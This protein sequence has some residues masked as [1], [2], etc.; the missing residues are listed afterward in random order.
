[1]TKEIPDLRPDQIQD[2]AF[3]LSNPKCGNLSDPGTGK[4]PSVCVYANYRWK[5]HGERTCWEMPKSLLLKN[6]EELIRFTEFEADDVLIFDHWWERVNSR[7]QYRV[8]KI[9]DLFKEDPPLNELK[10]RK[11]LSEIDFMNVE[12]AFREIVQYQDQI[13]SEVESK[14]K[15]HK[16]RVKGKMVTIQPLMPEI[17]R[18]NFDPIPPKVPVYLMGFTARKLHW[19][20]LPEDTTL[21]LVDEWHMAYGTSDSAQSQSLF[22][23][24][25]KLFTH[26]VAM[27]GTLMNG[28]LD[29]TY[30]FIHCVQPLYYGNYQHFLRIHAGFIDDYGRVL[31]WTKTE[32]VREIL[33]RHGV[34]HSFAEVY[35]EENKVTMIEKVAM[36]EKHRSF[37]D[38]FHDEAMLEL[39]DGWLEGDLPGVATIRATQIMA[40]PEVF[41]LDIGG[42]SEKDERVKLHLVNA[43]EN[44]T[45]IVLFA[46]LVPEQERLVELCKEHGLRTGLINGNVSDRKRG[47]IDQAFRNGE[48]D[49]VVAS[50][51]TASV[52]FNWGHVDHIIFVS[53]DY[54]DTSFLQA[55]RRAMRGVRE[56]PLRITLLQYDESIDQRK[57][58]IVVEKSV[59]A[60]EVDPTREI[61]VA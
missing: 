19:K 49:A 31:E 57:W 42:A 41:G 23:A 51:Q 53:V 10:L 61:L 43:K 17:L 22:R 36:G 5:Y 44:N 3:Y 24:M 25:R 20:K 6:K 15:V 39:E 28:R 26:M 40:H 56:K 8:G 9:R 38:K 37:Y 54:M 2:L 32:R 30:V 7:Y 50:P 58:A 52:G 14:L 33:G 12:E 34:R 60:N 29:S 1:M 35:G 27:T 48:L 46:N 16:E 18:E 45:P 4:T 59:L 13:R 11:I 55:Y 47:E 21:L